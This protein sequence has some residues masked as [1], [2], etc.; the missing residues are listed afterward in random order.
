MKH[1]LEGENE[2]FD[3]FTRGDEKTGNFLQVLAML[4]YLLKIVVPPQFHY[5]ILTRYGH[6]ILHWYEAFLDILMTLD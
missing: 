1:G 2:E 6:P 3:G 5:G 4:D